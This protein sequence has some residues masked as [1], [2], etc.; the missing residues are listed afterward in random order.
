MHWAFVPAQHGRVCFSVYCE[1]SLKGWEQVTYLPSLLHLPQTT[2]A[3]SLTFL[4]KPA[5]AWGARQG[6]AQLPRRGQGRCGAGGAVLAP[7]AR[8]SS[9]P[10]VS[11]GGCPG[12]RQEQPRPAGTTTPSAPLGGGESGCPGSRVLLQAAA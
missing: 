5:P 7:R 3:C 11:A 6:Q 10:A 12:R 9:A 1:D 8:C 2:M 4:R